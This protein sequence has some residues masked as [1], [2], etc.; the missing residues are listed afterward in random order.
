LNVNRRDFSATFL[1][2]GFGA[3]AL[4]LTVSAQS[5]AP[6]EGTQFTRVDPPV[7]LMAPG[8]IEVLEF[9]S[10]ACPHCSS[11][12]PTLEAWI[13]KLPPDVAFHRVPAPFLMNAE[14]F[15][16]T[17]YA[18]E[19]MGQVDALQRKIF[20]AIHVD[21]MRL[22]K[23]AD[24]AALVGKNGVDSAKFLDVFNSFSVATS[25]ARAKKLAAAYKLD[26]VPMLM[27]NGHY[28]TSPSQAGGPEQAVAV[29][30]FLIQRS[31]KG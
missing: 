21:R 7:P 1:A 10:Y 14:S 24:I 28:A 30:E 19:T 17:Y 4:P 16:R 8:K 23:P 9:F 12:E 29:A 2:A 3:V 5:G 6:A 27:I 11:F 13:K 15:M 22:D 25:V 20:A 31:R 26:S 18:L